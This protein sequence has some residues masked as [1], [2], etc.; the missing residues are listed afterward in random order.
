MDVVKSK[1]TFSDICPV[2]PSIWVWVYI[3]GENGDVLLSSSMRF[4]GF[5]TK[6]GLLSGVLRLGVWP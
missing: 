4:V 3:C 2:L 5:E 6:V 1:R